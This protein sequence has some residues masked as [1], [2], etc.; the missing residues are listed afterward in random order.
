MITKRKLKTHLLHQHSCRIT[1]VTLAVLF[2]MFGTPYATKGAI[3]NEDFENGITLVGGVSQSNLPNWTVSNNPNTFV[4]GTD[5]SSLYGFAPHSGKIAT[6]YFSDTGASDSG[7]S[8]TQT[9]TT[10]AGQ[11][12]TISLYVANAIADTGNLNNEFSIGWGGNAPANLITL[13]G[14]NVVP[15]G[16]NKYE[17]AGDPNPITVWHLVTATATATGT[18]TDFVINAR[19]NDWQTLVDDVMVDVVPEPSTAVL[20][21][22]GS[23]LFGF[24][25]RRQ[26]SL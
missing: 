3:V 18:S 10:V 21:G 24:R 2:C 1:G 22:I 9:L 23:A 25:R 11:T 26:K 7:G 20:L 13:A 19:N 6:R 15:I 8:I 16:G 4:N 14:T 17:V 5:T 12:Y